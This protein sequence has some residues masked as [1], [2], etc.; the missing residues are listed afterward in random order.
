M[1]S[2]DN[3][4]YA[5]ALA[6]VRGAI[7]QFAGCSDEERAAL[8]ADLDQL[9]QMASKLESGRVEIVVFG[10][11][12][13]GKSATINALVGSAA[14]DVN[15]QGGWTKDVWRVPWDGCGYLVPGFAESQVVLVDTPGLNEVDGAQ[16]A[17]MAHDAA[18]RA[19]LVLFVTD[20]DLNDTEYSALVELAA[21][22]KPILLVLNKTDLY[23]PEELASIL[24]VLRGPRL[25]DIVEPRD[26]LTAAANPKHVQYIIEAADGSTRTEQRRPQPDVEN[27]RVR[28]L[29]VLQREGKELL[30]LSAAM[31]A[32]D[33]SDRMASV[34]VRMREDRAQAMI[35]SFAV[36]KSVAVAI[37]PVPAADVLG[38]G[39]VDVTMVMTLAKVYGIKLTTANARSLVASIV[40]AAGWVMLG[41]GVT[42]LA[43][44]V[45][46]GLTL[47]YGTVLTALPQGAA[48]GYGSY[49]VGQ[50]ARYYFENGASWG[51]EGSKTVVHRI[52]ETTDRESILKRLKDEIKKKIRLNPYSGK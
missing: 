4:S 51:Q 46:K 11:I 39:A 21:S 50:A 38:G 8:R 28:V 52:L 44:M 29:E 49:V 1:S 30:A 27:V 14:T 3:S 24:S 16:R 2:A 12:S 17:A 15:V 35:W 33:R 19:D 43:S 45:F 5:S 36:V 34:R 22:H 6:S 10:E 13:T 31:Y 20:S 40:K 32:A 9:Q 42:H 18:Q 47:G 48:A 7:E 25:A 41:E 23:G 26:V 37:N